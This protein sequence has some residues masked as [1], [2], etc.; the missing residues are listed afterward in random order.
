[1]ANPHWHER[2]R[3]ALAKQGLPAAYSA[4]LLEELAG[5]WDDLQKEHGSMEA[6]SAEERLGAPELL[7]ALAKAEYRKRSFAGRHPFLAF[8]VGP[9][10]TTIVTW[11]ILILLCVPL[12]SLVA[13]YMPVRAAPP[14]R[15][16][17]TLVYAIVLFL[18][19][20]PFAV[21]A[22]VFV[23]LGRASCR[24]VW[25]LVAGGIV[26]YLAFV[27]KLEVAPPTEKHNLAVFLGLH[28][29]LIHWHA[30]LLQAALPL[31]L[32]IWAWRRLGNSTGASSPSLP[33]NAA[34]SL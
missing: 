12:K 19:F 33:M 9:F 23:R 21:L 13:P 15:F 7:A 10:L 4:S 3:Q 5:H 11:H 32:S 22:P 14:T 6:L 24:P 34:T 20:V 18:R 30:R 28:F 27:I 2:L 1:M 25:G 29:G 8:V 26:A 17:W 16:E 31:A